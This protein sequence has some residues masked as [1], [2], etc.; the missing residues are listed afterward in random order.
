MSNHEEIFDDDFPI[1][2]LVDEDGIEHHFELLAEFGIES[3]TYKVL[4]PL[5][6][7]ANESEDDEVEISFFKVVYDEEGNEFLSYIEDD[8]E[9]EMVVDT[10][11]ELDEIED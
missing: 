10:W 6:D 9:W 3:S 2:I 1:M 11:K 7:D 8:E 4:I 5:L